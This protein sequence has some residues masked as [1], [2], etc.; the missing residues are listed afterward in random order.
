MQ[1]SFCWYLC[2][3][4]MRLRYSVIAILM[5]SFFGLAKYEALAAARFDA[6]VSYHK[7]PASFSNHFIHAFPDPE[8]VLEEDELDEANF[9]LC[10][11]GAN[12]IIPSVKAFSV[13]NRYRAASALPLYLL[14]C[15][16]KY[17]LVYCS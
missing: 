1:V 6:V 11:K 12:T 16:W 15:R 13:L 17:H 9:V 14:Y 5:V 2:S 8:S 3:N 7:L 4:N 10:K